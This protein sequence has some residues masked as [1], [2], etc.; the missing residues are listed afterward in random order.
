[1]LVYI[2]GHSKHIEQNQEGSGLSLPFFDKVAF[3]TITQQVIQCLSN[4]YALP[5]KNNQKGEGLNSILMTY[6]KKKK[7]RTKKVESF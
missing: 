5:P 3:G 7:S 6:D 4:S 1:M 2:S